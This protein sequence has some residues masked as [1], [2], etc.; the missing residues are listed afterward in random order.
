MYNRST[1]GPV[2]YYFAERA[3]ECLD[4]ARREQVNAARAMVLRK[5]AVSGDHDAIDLHG[6]TVTEAEVIVLEMLGKR[7]QG[8]L[9]IITGRG[10]HSIGG[11]SVLKPALKKRLSEEGYA[12]KAWDAGLVVTIS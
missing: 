10:N 2:A 6:T 5:Q 7:R 1:Q 11:A 8:Q 9:K 4:A 3:Q 12:V